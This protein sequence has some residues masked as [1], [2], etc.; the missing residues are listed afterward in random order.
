MIAIKNRK[1]KKKNNKKKNRKTQQHK[2][3]Y[4]VF[5]NRRFKKN[6]ESLLIF[7]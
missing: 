3:E 1:Q 7:L 5:V 2:A 4:G 6:M